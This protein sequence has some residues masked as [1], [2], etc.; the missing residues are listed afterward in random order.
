VKFRRKS[1]GT[2]DE[3]QTSGPSETAAV[4]QEAAGREGGPFDESQ[5]VDDGVQRVDLGSLLVPPIEGRELRLQVDEQS[6]AVRAVILAG[7]DGALEFQAFAAPRNGDL[8]ETVRPQ[9]ADDLARRGG[10]AEER[11]GR[12]GTE[13]VCTMPVTRPDGTAAVQP[14]RIIGVNGERWLLRASLLGRPAIEP[15]TAGEWEDAL[16]QVVVRRGKVAMPV[17]EPLPVTLPADAR[18]LG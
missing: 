5:V 16:A 9:I 7:P 12:W 1:S 8:W 11:Q 17:G 4:P 6:G 18:P 3:G 13:L 10:T 15:D 14:S 2:P